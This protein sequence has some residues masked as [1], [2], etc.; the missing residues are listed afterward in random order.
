MISMHPFTTQKRNRSLKDGTIG[1]KRIPS[2]SRST[3]NRQNGDNHNGVKGKE[4]DNDDDEDE[5]DENIRILSKEDFENAIKLVTNNKINNTNTWEVP[6]IEYF[7]D[8]NHLRS[9]DGVS[10]NFQMAS[11]TLDG[12]TKVIS[13]RVDSVA[14]DT[15]ALIQILAINEDS[16]TKKKKR[17][18]NGDDDDDD[19]EDDEKNDPNYQNAKPKRHLKQND[20]DNKHLVSV[21]KIK[22]N[23]RHIQFATID[24]VFRKMLADFDEG[25]AKSLLLNSL[26]VSTNGRV[27]LDDATTKTSIFDDKENSEKNDLVLDNSIVKNETKEDSSMDID[28]NTTKVKEED[29]QNVAALVSS[30]KNIVHENNFNDL[31]ICEEIREIKSSIE[32]I[33]YGKKYLSKIS[34]KIERDNV[35]EEEMPMPQFNV[36]YDY[37]IDNFDLNK[38]PGDNYNLSENTHLDSVLPDL[39]PEPYE[40]FNY[41]GVKDNDNDNDVSMLDEEEIIKKESLLM[42]ELDKR[43]NTRSK[44]H[45]KIRAFNNSNSNNNNTYSL[46]NKEINDPFKNNNDGVQTNT[47]NNTEKDVSSSKNKLNRRKKNEFIIDFMNDSE[48]TDTSTLFEKPTRPLKRLNPDKINSDITTL[49]DLK[50]WNSE[51]LVKSLLKPKRRFKNIFTKRTNKS[52]SSG[53]NADRDFWAAKYNDQDIM[54]KD[55]LDE[56][57]ADFLYEVMDKKTEEDLSDDKVNSEVGGDDDFG[58]DNDPGDYDFDAP[59]GDE[60][61]VIEPH[62]SSDQAQDSHQQSLKSEIIPARRSSWRNDSIHFEK[63]SKKINVRLLKQ[64]LWEATKIHVALDDVKNQSYMAEGNETQMSG[65]ID[66][67]LSDIVKDTIEKYEGREKSD[68]S[69]SFFF[70]CMLHIANEEGLSIEKTDDLSDLIIHPSGN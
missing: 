70:I 41:T 27:L 37:D 40:P 30:F 24:P 46:I 67:R 66:I 10:I 19:E 45:W 47:G 48:A 28:D 50:T 14:V 29:F 54:Q 38:E 39:N 18:I 16:K 44:Q 22:Y 1:R 68:L 64:N 11:A 23:D 60:F 6:L 13:K 49:P 69:T 59:I 35:Q 61:P 53:I 32:D 36:E 4:R 55:A 63:R 21:E 58:M 43:S 25:G 42:A 5:D 8:M 12:C 2:N 33:D 15:D 20:D 26:R 56:D 17:R 62:D 57:A 7:Y 3:V 9:D 31:D 52:L 51:R 65:S 34:E